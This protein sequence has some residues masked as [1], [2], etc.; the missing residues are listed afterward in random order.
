MEGEGRQFAVYA[1]TD[2]VMRV[3][4]MAGLLG[5]GLVFASAE[6]ALAALGES[7]SA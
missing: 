3:L 6:E 4:T 7:A 2:Q 5:N 1:P